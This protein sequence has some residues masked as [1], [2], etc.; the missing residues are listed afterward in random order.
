MRCPYCDI[1]DSKVTDSRIVEN[2]VR[3]R[4][5]CQGCGVRFT[6]YERVQS[7][8]LMVTKRDGR[9]EEFD[10]DKIISGIRKAC[11]KR[12]VSSRTIEKIVEEIEGE[13]PT[14]GHADVP[15]SVVGSMVM[16]RLRHVDEVAYI[17]WASVYRNF[18]EIESF[19]RAVQDLRE[20]TQLP[21]LEDAPLPK[22]RTRRRVPAGATQARSARNGV[23]KS[24]EGGQS[25]EATAEVNE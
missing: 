9:R 18:E 2:G 6:T 16:D 15:T 19:E 13:L 8:S 22:R 14:M 21:L 24:D 20:D 3:R 1:L 25:E 4:R 17:R 7:N 5:E 23:G 10:R 12:P 11:T